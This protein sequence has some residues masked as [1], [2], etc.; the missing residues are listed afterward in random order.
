MRISPINVDR[1]VQDLSVGVK[2][3]IG[4]EITMC[5]ELIDGDLKKDSVA[6]VYFQ[7]ELFESLDEKVQHKIVLAVTKRFSGNK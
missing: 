3:D 1:T 5:G 7:K 4:T 6:P 2:L